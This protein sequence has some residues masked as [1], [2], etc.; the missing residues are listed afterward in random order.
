MIIKESTNLLTQ[1]KSS[2]E[3]G[4]IERISELSLMLQSAINVFDETGELLVDTFYPRVSRFNPEDAVK[5]VVGLFANEGS[6]VT[7]L[8]KESLQSAPE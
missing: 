2:P 8:K 5:R 1:T 3:D 4:K 7:F 6:S